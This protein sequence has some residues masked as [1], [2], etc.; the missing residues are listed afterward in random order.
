MKCVTN[1]VTGWIELIIYTYVY[2]WCVTLFVRTGEAKYL[3]VSN[4]ANFRYVDSTESLV[5]YR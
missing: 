1:L 2:C 3:S 4:Y 5:T